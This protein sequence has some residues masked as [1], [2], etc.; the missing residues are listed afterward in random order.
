MRNGP[1]RLAGLVLAAVGALAGCGTTPASTAPAAPV[2]GAVAGDSAPATAT[3]SPSP[4]V[5]EGP[6]ASA[7]MICGP[8]AQEKITQALGLTLRRSATS[9]WTAPVYRCTYPFTAGPLVLSVREFADASATTAYFTTARAA[10]RSTE[11]Q[12]LGDAAFTTTYG[13]VYVR[14]DFKVLEVDV[15]G[16]PAAVGTASISRAD[17]AFVIAQLIMGCWTGQ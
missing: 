9:L 14:K 1:V 8:E 16:L 11:L 15:S 6:S 5:A 3:G 7:R 10:G 2:A 4:A 17:A 13:S 12:G